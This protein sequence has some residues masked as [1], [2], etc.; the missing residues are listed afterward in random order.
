M[1][2]KTNFA[3]GA[4]QAGKKD[5]TVAYKVIRSN[6]TLR[7]TVRRVGNGS[8]VLF[9]INNGKNSIPNYIDFSNNGGVFHVTGNKKGYENIT[10]PFKCEVNSSVNY[11]VNQFNNKGALLND[12]EIEIYEPGFWEVNFRFKI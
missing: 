9:S 11:M 12:F 2:S 10:F 8:T 6:P 5:T 4:I 3:G 1:I 7:Y